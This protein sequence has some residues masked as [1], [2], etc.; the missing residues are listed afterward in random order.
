MASS[1]KDA[2]YTVEHRR[3]EGTQ[4]DWFGIASAARDDLQARVNQQPMWLRGIW[5]LKPSQLDR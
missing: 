4:R 1:K 2:R 3:L 5:H